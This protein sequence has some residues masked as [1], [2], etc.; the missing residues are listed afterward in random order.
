M[1]GAAYH[2]TAYCVWEITLACNQACRHC[3]SRGGRPRAAEL[4][5][6]EALDVV[7]QLADLGIGEVTLIGGEAFL[8]RDWL[9][10][11]RAITDAGMLCSI[12]TGGYA[13]TEPMVRAMREAGVGQVSVSVDGLE[14]AHD[15]LRGR[16][17]LWRACFETMAH[18]RRVGMPIA[19][20][21][22][23]N[24]RTAGDLPMLYKCLRAAGMRA[25]QLQLTLPMGQA[26]DHPEMILQPVELLDVFPVLAHLKLRADRDGVVVVPSDNVGYFGPFE[27][28]LRGDRDGWHPWIGCYAGLNVIG[29]EAD[30]TVKGCASLPSRAYGG[31][32]V[33]ERSLRAIV[34]EAAELDLNRGARTDHLWGFCSTCEHAALCRG[35]CTWTSHA[36]FGRRGN[37]PLC[38]HRALALEARGR[39]ERLVLERPAGDQPFATGEFALIEEPLDAPWPD[40]DPL[41]LD[42][43]AMRWPAA[44]SPSGEDLVA[45]NPEASVPGG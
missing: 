10:L 33:R 27:R 11:A 36:F 5:P 23:I 29:L 15:L 25:W 1:A 6:D 28:L 37:N 19:I 35:G 7:R 40:D 43:S 2:R 17:G 8:R 13:V 44:W 30:G 3:G 18:L 9:T 38:H 39:R 20:N 22:Q 45:G 12:T 31:G 21:T 14:P 4:T 24:R 26:A 34:E 41:H 32:N 16:P 42:A